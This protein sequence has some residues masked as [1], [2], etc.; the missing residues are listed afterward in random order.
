[1]TL[2]SNH[3]SILGLITEALNHPLLRLQLK[4]VFMNMSI[5]LRSAVLIIAALQAL[6]IA[7][8][9]LYRSTKTKQYSD[10][11]LALSLLAF[12]GTLGEH[13]AGWLGWYEDQKLT[14]FP[15]GDA[16]LFPPL[17]YLYVK[18][19]TNTAFQLTRRTSLYFTPAA[20]YFI[21]HLVVWSFPVTEKLD[22]I[23]NLWRWRFWHIQSIINL[24]VF[25]FFTFK[26]TQHY[27]AYRQWLPT[28][29]SNTEKLTLK[30]LGTF[31]LLLAFAYFINLGFELYGLF[32]PTGYAIDFWKYFIA[33]IVIYYIS[34]TG[35]AYTQR[36]NVL[37]DT[38]KPII[39]A[40]QTPDLKQN[41]S[42]NIILNADLER[43]KY[44]L[45]DYLKTSQRY[46]EPDLMLSKLA[47]EL[48]I[49][50]SLLSQ[51][52]NSCYHKNFN[53]FIN[54]YRVNAVIEKFKAGVHREQTFLAIALDCGF[55]S[56]A[57]FNR[58][59]KKMT[60]LSPKEY[61]QQLNESA[62]FF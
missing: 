14:F 35:Y 8:L 4:G 40:L 19:L 5:S 49:A 60:S 23:N 52:I 2:F 15:F 29:Y 9:L 42:E 39:E 53:D 46:L 12:A 24:A 33:A 61:V 43:I 28:E 22:I 58:V 16:F 13:I 20:I 26:T 44:L 36:T 50:P 1:M 27:I 48:K 54:A 57:T 11:F 38:E 45:E 32:L 7:A 34:V 17:A 3:R 30:W 25:T 31:V 51:T 55:N 62:H 6:V 10:V 37:F 18:S 59:F 56:K 21:F 47:D 41:K